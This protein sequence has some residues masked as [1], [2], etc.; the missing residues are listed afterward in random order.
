[1][2]RDPLAAQLDE[3][4]G[5]KDLPRAGWTRAGVAGPESVAAHSW[6]MSLLALILCPD[7]LDRA[8][9]LALCALH[10]LPEV[11]AGD[12]TP[13]DGVPA[14][15]KARRERVAAAGLLGARPDLWGLWED[16]ELSRTAEA[17]FAHDL[18]KLDMGLQAIRYARLHGVDTQEF[19]DS[20]AR[21]IAD[22]RLRL[23][24]SELAEA[25]TL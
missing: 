10:D 25:A 19:I 15:E 16:Y 8:R 6:G 22:P 4:L 21:K 14:E 2:S 20:A 24:L 18:D 7:H 13:H 1:M 12:I 23:L 17:R 11:R 5:L 9:V 3:I